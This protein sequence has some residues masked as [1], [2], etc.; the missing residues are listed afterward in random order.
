MMLDRRRCA[1]ILCGLAS[2]LDL[3]A[4]QSL[5]PMLAEQLHATPVAVSFTVSM[6]PLAIALVA[7]WT[8]VIADVLGRQRV[9]VAAI[10]ALVVPTVM[11][12]FSTT[13]GANQVQIITAHFD[14]P[15]RGHYEAD[16]DLDTDIGPQTVHLIADATGR[17]FDRTSVYACQ[18]NGGSVA[19]G[20]PILLALILVRRRRGSSSPR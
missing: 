17:D 6:P 20:W 1:V 7:P 16:L 11:V 4:T 8:G 2:F 18:C 5:L 13:L 14:P 10:F 3:W 12:G 15:G 19:G 9:I